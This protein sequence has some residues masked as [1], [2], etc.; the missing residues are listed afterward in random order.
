MIAESIFNRHRWFSFTNRTG[1]INEM[2]IVAMKLHTR[3]QAPKEGQ[4]EAPKQP[5]VSECLM[6]QRFC[7]T[8]TPKQTPKIHSFE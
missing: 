8:H 7:V 5:M 4:Q 2:R 6:Q 1:F 3:D